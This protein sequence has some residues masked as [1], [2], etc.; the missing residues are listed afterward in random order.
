MDKA[1]VAPFLFDIMRSEVDGP[2][3]QFQSTIFD[4]EDI[5]K[6]ITMLNEACGKDRLPDKRL[7]DYHCS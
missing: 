4:K 1:Y 5:K 3:A 6:L 7:L 2:I